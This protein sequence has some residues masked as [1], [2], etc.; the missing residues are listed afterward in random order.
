MP[1]PAT[2]RP[3]AVR[4]PDGARVRVDVSRFGPE[5]LVRPAPTGP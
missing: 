2:W 1:G 3:V 5:V 4:M